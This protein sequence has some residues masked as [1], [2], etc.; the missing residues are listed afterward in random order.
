MA[1]TFTTE[2][3]IPLSFAEAAAGV[4]ARCQFEQLVP[5]KGPNLR[6]VV[7]RKVAKGLTGVSGSSRL[8]PSHDVISWVPSSMPLPGQFVKR[9]LLTQGECLY[10]R[11]LS[12]LR[13]PCA[14]REKAPLRSLTDLW[15]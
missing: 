3:S 9:G 7:L 8:F 10:K 13:E 2:S 6:K 15:N 4:P 12:W 5:V 14:W 1:R 11:H